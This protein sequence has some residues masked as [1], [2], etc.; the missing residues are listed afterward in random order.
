VPK[1]RAAAA[2]GA[3]LSAKLTKA[4]GSVVDYGIVSDINEAELEALTAA[5]DAVA[6]EHV[7]DTEAQDI[8]AAEEANRAESERNEAANRQAIADAAEDT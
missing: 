6:E 7:P 2:G 1:A 3:T 5:L 4:D 8:A